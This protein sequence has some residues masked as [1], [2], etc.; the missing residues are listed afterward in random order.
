MCQ[1]LQCTLR[2]TMLLHEQQAC[3]VAERAVTATKESADR[4]LNNFSRPSTAPPTNY[5]PARSFSVPVKHATTSRLNRTA[6]RGSLRG[7]LV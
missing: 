5:K 3:L 1:Y 2:C 7:W 4:V 6:A